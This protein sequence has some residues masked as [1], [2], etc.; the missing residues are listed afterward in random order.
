MQVA[1]A[2]VEDVGDAQAVAG[3]DLADALST[4]GRRPVGMTPSMQM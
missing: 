2:G 1:V 3:A 4:S